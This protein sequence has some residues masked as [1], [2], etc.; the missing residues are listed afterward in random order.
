MITLGRTCRG[1][2]KLEMA[3]AVASFKALL[4]IAL[5]AFVWLLND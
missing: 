4:T 3:L 1:E 5:K 2:K